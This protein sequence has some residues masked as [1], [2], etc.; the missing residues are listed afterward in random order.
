MTSRYQ[1]GDELGYE[2]T[3]DANWSFVGSNEPVKNSC[4]V[5]HLIAETLS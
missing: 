1:L 2:D 4:E 3:D 5:I